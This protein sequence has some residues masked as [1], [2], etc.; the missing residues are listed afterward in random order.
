MPAAH[1][2]PAPSF[3][4]GAHADP[5]GHVKLQER[6]PSSAGTPTLG[7]Y[8]PTS[9]KVHAPA[10]GALTEPG[11]QGM[12]AA[13]PPA[14]AEPAGHGSP[15][16]LADPGGQKEPRGV[17]CAQLMQLVSGVVAP[18]SGSRNV[19][20]GHGAHDALP[21]SLTKPAGHGTGGAA[22]PAQL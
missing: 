17:S 6:Q 9:H 20:L 4:P 16:K 1:A 11:A 2:V 21:T 18:C 10:P 5:G 13:A 7:W 15:K 22:P 3:E 19:P 8:L 12:G 14:H